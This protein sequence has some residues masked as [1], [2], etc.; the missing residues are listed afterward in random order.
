MNWLLLERVIQLVTRVGSRQTLAKQWHPKW[1]ETQKR[2]RLL[3]V[4]MTGIQ[5]A[6]DLLKWDKAQ[7]QSFYSKVKSISINAANLYHDKL[8]INRS[9]RIT[10]LK[11]EGTIS[12]LPTVSSGIHSAY[13]PYYYRRVRFSKSDPLSKVLLEA[14]LKPTP[15]NS[16]GDDL[17]A[18]QCNTWVFT[19]PIKT[20]TKVRAIDIP[21]I[22]QLK[23]YLN[24]QTYYADR[25]HNVSFTC[26]LAPNE[27]KKAAKWT[28]D[29]WD[30]IIGISFLPR[31]DPQ[32]SSNIFVKLFNKLTGKVSKP[33]YPQLPYETCTETE[34]HE[35]KSTIPNLT[36]HELIELLKVHEREYEEMELDSDCNSKGFCPVR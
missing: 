6:F 16:Q 26:T 13:A 35:L 20:K 11:P 23:E 36:E 19:F 3:G 32:G 14:G 17:F 10:L 30:S 33:A 2:D 9:T 28:Y 31:Y 8:G 21:A 24:A 25:G 34:Y 7:K 15:E 5:D 29:N 12:Q 18:E 22:K 27:Y 1:D 4:S